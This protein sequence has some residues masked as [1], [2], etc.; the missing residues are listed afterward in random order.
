MVMLRSS[1]FYSLQMLMLIW[2]RMW[3]WFCIYLLYLCQE[4]ETALSLPCMKCSVQIVSELLLYGADFDNI[5]ESD[6]TR[7]IHLFGI[8]FQN[9]DEISNWI[10]RK[11]WLIFLASTTT[12]SSNEHKKQNFAVLNINEITRY[13]SEFLWIELSLEWRN[14]MESSRIF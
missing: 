9:I 5:S 2:R 8:D 6:E 1:L 4:G 11:S 12:S 10:A 3:V 13:I 7:L 14:L